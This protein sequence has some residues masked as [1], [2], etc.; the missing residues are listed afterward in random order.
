M[1]YASSPIGCI[2]AGGK[3]ERMGGVCKPL[4]TI[5]SKSLLELQIAALKPQTRSLLVSTARVANLLSHSNIAVV[6]DAQCGEQYIQ[7]GPLAGV[8]SALDWL[9]REHTDS[10][11]LLTIPGDTVCI[12]RNFSELLMNS[13]RLHQSVDAKCAFAVCD[14]NPYYLAAL[15]HRD[16]L[17]DLRHYLDSGERKVSRFLCGQN[18]VK[19]EF[20]RTNTASLPPFFN[21]NTQDDYDYA[22]AA[23]ANKNL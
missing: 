21:I 1:V 9:N 18:A 19:V 14:N 20:S 5:G 11:W 15:W 10:D 13:I 4:L 8:V 7:Q 22:K 16:C 6:T 12:P 23:M 17:A 2:L 3:G